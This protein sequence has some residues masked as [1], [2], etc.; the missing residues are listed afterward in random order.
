MY[1]G[2]PYSPIPNPKSKKVAVSYSTF[3]LNRQRSIHS[4][5]L[6]SYIGLIS[7]QS[8]S[9]KPHLGSNKGKTERHTL[10][11]CP[12]FRTFEITLGQV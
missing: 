6:L 10:G 12:F 2:L 8:Q 9:E 5:F 4:L 3:L 1:K 11:D 7:Y